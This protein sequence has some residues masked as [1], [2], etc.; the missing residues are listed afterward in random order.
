MTL[1]GFVQA[2]EGL[3]DVLHLPPEALEHAPRPD[4]AG[5]RPWLPP[6]DPYAAQFAAKIALAC[7]LALIVGVASHARALETI[8][9]NPLILAQGSYGATIR[10]PA[11]AWPAWSAAAC[12]RC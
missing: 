8:I 1:N 7:L 4:E 12:W 5:P 10:K 2:L 3:A 11:C 9:L 6:F